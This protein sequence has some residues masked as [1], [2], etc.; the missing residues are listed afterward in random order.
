MLENSQKHLAAARVVRPVAAEDDGF[1]ASVDTKAVGDT[2]VALGGGRRR[3]EDH[4]DPSVGLSH[5]KSIG[6]PVARGEPLGR[7]HAASEEAWQA[8]AVGLRRAYRV[9]NAAPAEM[10]VVHSI[11]EGASDH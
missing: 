1:I 10:P 3:V 5:L 2:V 7:V 6:E 11:V 4:I 9:T 8:A